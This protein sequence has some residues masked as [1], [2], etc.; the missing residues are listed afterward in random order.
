[1]GGP[2]KTLKT[3]FSCS[4]H[5]GISTVVLAIRI[6]KLHTVQTCRIFCTE[7]NLLLLF[8]QVQPY[9]KII[10]NMGPDEGA[11]SRPLICTGFI[12][13]DHLTEHLFGLSDLWH[14]FCFLYSWMCLKP[15][16]FWDGFWYLRAAQPNQVRLISKMVSN[17]TGHQ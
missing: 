4:H 9:L 17:N 15:P 1:M 11:M 5:S 10:Q 2:E 6:Q 12:S 7:K 14:S 13:N 16:S 3:L 8:S